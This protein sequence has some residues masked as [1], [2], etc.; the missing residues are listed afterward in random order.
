MNFNRQI[1]KGVFMKEIAKEKIVQLDANEKS[2]L[3][4]EVKETLVKKE[5]SNKEAH[6]TALDLWNNQRNFRTASSMMSK[7]NLN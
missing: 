3:T 7:W 2:K 5:N 1:K 4:Q 6:F